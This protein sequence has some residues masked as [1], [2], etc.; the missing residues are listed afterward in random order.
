MVPSK[1]SSSDS[2]AALVLLIVKAMCFRGN[3]TLKLIIIFFL[4][5]GGKF[6]PCVVKVFGICFFFFF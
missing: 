5:F 6:N 1:S 3:H 4:G 2:F